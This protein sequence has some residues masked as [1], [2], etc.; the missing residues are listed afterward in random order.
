MKWETQACALSRYHRNQLEFLKKKT[1]SAYS[2][3]C[4]LDTVSSS[5]YFVDILIV[6][7]IEFYKIWFHLI[8]F[9]VS[10]PLEL[11]ID[12]HL[13]RPLIAVLL[14]SPSVGIKK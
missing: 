11:I 12:K 7:D 3:F 6:I 1:S 10:S 4:P 9:L 14:L 13:T 8:P 2:V 5:F